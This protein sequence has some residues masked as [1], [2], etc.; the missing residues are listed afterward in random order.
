MWTLAADGPREMIFQE[1]LL[2]LLCSWI[3]TD[4][5]NLHSNET[6]RTRQCPQE[7]ICHP[8]LSSWVEFNYPTN[9]G[10]AMPDIGY[11]PRHFKWK[12]LCIPE[13]A[14][15]G[16]GT[17]NLGMWNLW[18]VPW[19]RCYSLRPKNHCAFVRVIREGLGASPKPWPLLDK[20]S[21]S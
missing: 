5:D 9:L 10:V 15:W 19:A 17:L 14:V 11:W 6:S 8:L 21:H 16:G 2:I 20:E 3:H 12:D 18:W 4:S 13:R 1:H 7:F